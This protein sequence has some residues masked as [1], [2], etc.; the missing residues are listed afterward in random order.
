MEVQMQ[1][2]EDVQAN[3]VRSEG[4]SSHDRV[5]GA[6]DTL[7]LLDRLERARR[8][9]ALSQDGGLD[10]AE[11][12]DTRSLTVIYF[13]I[14]QFKEFNGAFG[15]EE[16]N[17]CLRDIARALEGVFGRSC[18]SRF[19]ADHFIVFCGTGRVRRKIDQ[20]HESVMRLRDGFKLWLEAGVCAPYSEQSLSAA[21]DLAKVA[22][23]QIVKDGRSYSCWYSGKIEEELERKK[24]LQDHIG[25]AIEKGWVQVHYQPVIRTLTTRI[26]GV[27]ALSRWKDPIYGEVS[28]GVF[29]PALEEKHLSWHLLEFVVD[30]AC[31]DLSARYSRGLP[32][33]PVSVNVSRTDFES[34]EP[35]EVI[36]SAVE[37]HEVPP[38]L[39]C[40]EITESVAMR[41]P[42]GIEAVVERFRGAGYE[43]WMDDFG[44]AYSSLNTLKDFS[45]GKLKL[46]ML[47]M[48][49]FNER[50]KIIIGSII[51]MAKKLGVHTLA[52]G[53]ETKEQVDYLRDAGCEEIQGFYFS[54]PLPLDEAIAYASEHQPETHEQRTLYNE[55][56]LVKLS[57]SEAAGF[58]SWKDGAARLLYA[59][60]MLRR[61]MAADGFSLPA[62]MDALLNSEHGRFAQAY[63]QT[64]LRTIENGDTEAFAFAVNNQRYQLLFRIAARNDSECVLAVVVQEISSRGIVPMLEETGNPD[65]GSDGAEGLDD[66]PA[67]EDVPLVTSSAHGG[68]ASSA[69]AGTTP[70][71]AGRIRPVSLTVS[72]STQDELETFSALASIFVTLVIIDFRNWELQPVIVAEVCRGF[73]SGGGLDFRETIPKFLEQAV[74]ESYRDAMRRF[75]DPETIAS[76]LSTSGTLAIDYLGANVGWC[77]L[78]LIPIATDEAGRATKALFAARDINAEKDEESRLAYGMNHD[79]LTGAFN[80]NGLNMVIDM[81]RGNTAPMAYVMVDVD[82]FKEFN[83]EFGHKAGDDLLVRVVRMLIDT[84]GATD[85]VARIGGD[86]FA[87][88]LTRYDADEDGAAA[89]ERIGWVN[90][91]LRRGLE[92]LGGAYARASVSLSAGIVV[93]L[94]GFRNDFYE[95]A[96]R[97]LYDEKAEGKGGSRVKVLG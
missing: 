85:Y 28:P 25:Q 78:F 4:L 7:F 70:L 84:F 63:R 75:I 29:V 83:D 23:D 69:P 91:E 40:V 55:L 16:G 96:D 38:S 60:Q 5:S 53:V 33:V 32:V 22:C 77:R 24:Y 31:A 88:V 37:R 58:V 15:M 34:C 19:S 39:I 10:P 44:S 87:V 6:F 81:V 51:Q 47:F 35:F 43:V 86:E 30:R 13:N 62:E 46:D 68:L 8:G 80:R 94:D 9:Q 71:P 2:G 17:R 59:N 56:G 50:S 11:L 65:D 3:R 93:S 79:P 72:H 52:E 97:M 42:E 76:R 64:V 36:T 90:E 26:A 61:R 67:G 89:R 73:L 27:E 54:R 82:N 57:R 45:F 95:L 92:T 18:V 66:E 21:V 12:G 14:V 74:D 49:D 20:A 1:G 48:H 41:D